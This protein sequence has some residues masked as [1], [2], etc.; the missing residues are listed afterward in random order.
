MFIQKKRLYPVQYSIGANTGYANG[1]IMRRSLCVI[2]GMCALS[3]VLGGCATSPGAVSADSAGANMVPPPVATKVLDVKGA[4]NVNLKVYEFG[5]PNGRPIVFIHGI[6]QAHIAWN[7]QLGSE[8]AAKYRLVTF[9]LRGHGFSDKPADMA[10]Y[11]G[12]RNWA[13]D[14]NAVIVGLNLNK[15]VLVG[16]SFGGRVIAMYLRHYG[17]GNVGAIDF[18]GTVLRVSGNASGQRS[19]QLTA[20]VGKIMRAKSI[21]DYI[22]GQGAFVRAMSHKALR[23]EEFE[24]ILAFNMHVPPQVFKAVVTAG[25]FNYEPELRKLRVPT[26]VTHGQF[27]LVSNIGNGRF[28]AER[29]A[30]A[31]FSLFEDAGHLTFLEDTARFNR[32]LDALA[33]AVTRPCVSPE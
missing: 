32:E 31:R 8:L 20:A 7:K 3:F 28:I 4:N 18:V 6:N 29:V 2:V 22:E 1:V 14:L 30:G 16:W 33:L 13:D 23:N 12:E 17:E 9:D 26:L 15:P 19:P 21:Q 10:P 24:R 27:D 11:Q 5:N 25:D